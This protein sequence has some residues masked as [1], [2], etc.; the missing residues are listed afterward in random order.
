MK[1]KV[2]EKFRNGKLEL[3]FIFPDEEFYDF[4]KGFAPIKKDRLKIEF[5]GFND[6]L[7]TVKCI[8]NPGLKVYFLKEIKGVFEKAYSNFSLASE[9]LGMS[10]DDYNEKLE[11]RKRKNFDAFMKGFKSGFKK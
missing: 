10:Y 4:L 5:V 11:E 1:Y 8:I 9:I 6:R 7:L 2:E 3:F